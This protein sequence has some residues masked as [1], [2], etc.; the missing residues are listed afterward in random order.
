[1]EQF[2]ILLIWLAMGLVGLIAKAKNKQNERQ[3]PPDWLDDQWQELIQEQDP[4]AD[5]IV[6]QQ[7]KPT[8]QPPPI[9]VPAKTESAAFP[10]PAFTPAAAAPRTP[11]PL[12]HDTATPEMIPKRSR[13]R[14]P[15]RNRRTTVAQL[16][17][18][19]DSLRKAVLLREVVDRP[20][21]YDV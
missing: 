5:E 8:I 18:G 19:S 1:V 4:A 9:P 6:V 13:R 15:S 16:L 7:A 21:A 17:A 11:T 2:I 3:A 10:T 12:S 20:R 14:R